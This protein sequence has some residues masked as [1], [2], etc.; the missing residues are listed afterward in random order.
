MG[1]VGKGQAKKET[2]RER[3]LL[4]GFGGGLGEGLGGGDLGEGLGKALAL[5]ARATTSGLAEGPAIVRAFEGLACRAVAIVV[6]R[7]VAIV[8]RRAVAIRV[9]VAMAMELAP[10][11][12]MG[13]IGYGAYALFDAVR[14]EGESVE[15]GGAA[16]TAAVSADCE[17]ALSPSD[18]V[19][20]DTP[21]MGE[22]KVPVEELTD[23]DDDTSPVVLPD[24]RAVSK[25]VLSP[26]EFTALKAAKA[27]RKAK[28]TP[29]PRGRRPHPRLAPLPLPFPL[30]LSPPL[31]PPLPSHFLVLSPPLD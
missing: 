28:L 13:G 8:V 23:L 27:K 29:H 12:V 18:Y 25:Y 3:S 17:T 15:T 6:R 20:L 5:G 7:A 31:F 24:G 19:D 22:G 30:S 10:L 4:G 1:A 16:A 26:E 14:T 11:A 2:G 21:R 9:A